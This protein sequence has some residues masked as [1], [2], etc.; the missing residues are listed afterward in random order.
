[1]DRHHNAPP[2]AD[3]LEIDH[4]SLS[5]QARE[6]LNLPGLDP[7]MGDEDLE[8]YSERAKALKGVVSVIEKARKAEKDQI[9][10]D[11]RTIDD[12]FK[13][14][15]KPLEDAANAVVSAINVWQRAKLEAERKRQAEEAAKAREEAPPFE[16]TPRIVQAKP[17]EAARVVSSATGRVQAVA[18][19]VWRH[20]VTDPQAVPRQYLMVNEAAIKAAVAGGAR[21]IPGVRIF[22][23]VRTAI[24]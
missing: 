21:D 6:V 4:A 1:M 16:G 12:F 10:K 13:R 19:T 3:R 5:Q 22:E 15:A 8:A 7:I 14:L 18:S 11:G 17:Q 20:E 9:L 2:L 24:R 23:D